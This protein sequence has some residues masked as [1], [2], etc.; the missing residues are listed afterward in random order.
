MTHRARPRTRWITAVTAVLA[1]VAAL[2][3][4]TG[5]GTAEAAAPGQRS[6]HIEYFSGP[7]AEP[8]QVSVPARPAVH[9][10]AA[11]RPARRAA[12]P[13]VRPL[14]RTGPVSGRLDLVVMGDGYTADEQGDF[15]ADAEEKLDAIF[16]VEPYRSYRGLFNVWLVD[17]VSAESGVSGDPTADVV[18]DTALGSAFF[19][20]GLERLLCVDTDAVARYAHLAPDADIV[21]VVANSAKY[22]G[23]GYST[24][25]LPPT[26][27]FHGVATMS[28]DNERSYLIGA[29]ELG[30]SIGKLADEY[31]Y[32]GYGA[33]PYAEEPAAAN[34]TLTRDPATAKWSRWAGAQ[35]P[36]GSIVGT[37]KGGGY[38]ETG[39]HR[40]TDT[41]LMRTLASTEFNVVGREAMIA[42]FYADADAL[43]SPVPTTEPVR[44]NRPIPVRVAP[45]TGLADLHLTWCVD[46]REVPWAAGARVVTPHALGVHGHGHRVTAT[47]TDRSAALRNPVALARATNSLTWTIR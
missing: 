12:D 46:G 37:Y 1:A 7:A 30:H 21:F 5:S 2:A 43:T 26:S 22:G 14:E 15:A 4:G 35:D 39:I 13:A 6:Q 9:D 40:P 20:D 47:V 3:G 44:G 34:L 23:A 17:T 42:G 27:P 16:A 45:L 8:R 24:A 33:Y 38:Y 31:Q 19:C 10:E 32:P 41:S 29:H 11:R 25:D 28:S 18:K 36:T